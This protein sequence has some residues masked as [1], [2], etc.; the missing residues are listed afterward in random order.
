MTDN[1]VDSWFNNFARFQNK[2]FDM[3][4]TNEVTY[5][6]IY[7][8]SNFQGKVYMESTTPPTLGT[9]VGTIKS[10]MQMI[11]PVGSL[12]AYQTSYGSYITNIVEGSCPYPTR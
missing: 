3:V 9:P 4:I 1:G 5:I 8:L 12:S 2:S 6:G 7:L 10:N 11:V